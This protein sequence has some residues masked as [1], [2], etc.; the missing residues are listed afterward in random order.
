MKRLLFLFLMCLPMVVCAQDDVEMMT[1][2]YV[3]ADAMTKTQGS[4]KW[5]STHIGV[6]KWDDGR[7]GMG[8][9]N[10]PHIF[11]GKRAMDGSRLPMNTC[12]V[13]LYAEDGTLVWL[14]EKWKCQPGEGGTVLYFTADAKAENQQT[15]ERRKITTFDILSWLQQTGNYVRYIADV[16]GDYYWD[17]SGKFA[18]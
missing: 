18:E 9:M 12:K 6:T 13:G 2:T 8:L 15:G 1:P 11:I 10:P 17:V 4:T 7:V 5:R 14:A 3:K 16:Y